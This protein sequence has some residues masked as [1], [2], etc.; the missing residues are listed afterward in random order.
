MSK[1]RCNPEVLRRNAEVK[2]ASSEFSQETDMKEVDLM[3]L[4]HELQ[5]HQVELE[6]Q[7]EELRL[8]LAKV[9][10]YKIHLKNIIQ[11]APAGYFRLDREGFIR[12]V[13]KAWLEM[14][15]YDSSD[16][17]VGKHFS[18]MQVDSTLD[19]AITH[20]SELK[21]GKAIPYGE[22]SSRKKN[23]MVGHHVFSAHPIMHYGGVIGFEWFI[24]DISERIRLEEEKKV[25]EQQ[26]QQA[27]KLESLGI[28][29]GGIAHDF[30]N[31]LAIILSCCGMIKLN[32]ENADKF[33]PYIEKAVDRGAGLCRQMQIYAGEVS[34]IQSE[35]IMSILV[36]D[37]VKMLKATTCKNVVIKTS[38]T[39]DIS[40]INGDA[41]QLSQVLMNLIINASEAIG[42]AQGEIMVSLSGTDIKEGESFK[43]YRGKIIPAVR[44]LCLEVTDN[45]C[46][47]SD[48]TQRRLFE[49]FYST[50]FTG[51]GLG[52]SAVLG[53]IS[54]HSAMLQLT[55]QQ[56]KG[57]T[58][59]IYLPILIETAA[60]DSLKPESKSSWKGA[61]T[62]L[63]VEDEFEIREVTKVMLKN[64]GLTVIVAS[65]GKEALALYRKNA[66]DITLVLTDMAMPVM[67]GYELVSELKKRCPR[68]PI[69]LSSGFCK[70]KIITKIDPDAIAAFISKPYDF[71]QLQDVLR[72]V[73]GG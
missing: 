15:G 32:Y 4:Q 1:K 72:N 25:L 13:N 47:M 21:K 8:S 17:V 34:I 52:M 63:L 35:I 42:D 61:G 58:F 30:N 71:Y 44:Y 19:S 51:R 50:K 39:P 36:D 37:V 53:I 9:N 65:N 10:D 43:D 22:F 54:A 14:H 69:I 26:F 45:G 31:V 57:T 67:D 64:L 41:S 66:T 48:E 40:S 12:E 16:E 11:L 38:L 62:V 28:L 6:M 27:Q 20:I 5:V 59:K 24:I 56:G 73:L 7:N 55:S 46:G 33:L 2:L 18:V 49:P 3:R 68:L 29:S 23:G 70:D 60:K